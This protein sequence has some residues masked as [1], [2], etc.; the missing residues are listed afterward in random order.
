MFVALGSELPD[1]CHVP[2]ASVVLVLF[3]KANGGV[4]SEWL[5]LL[6]EVI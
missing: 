6:E 3:V 1:V 5:Q 4:R 2:L